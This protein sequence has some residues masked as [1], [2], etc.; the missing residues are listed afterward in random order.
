[1]GDFA[2][3]LGGGLHILPF[4]GIAI[5][6]PAS[7]II[8][9]RNLEAPDPL[10]GADFL[11]YFLSILGQKTSKFNSALRANYLAEEK[12]LQLCCVQGCLR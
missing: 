6:I 10:T 5:E 12:A 7:L 4:C 3:F 2:F 8:P 9:G 1:M 11:P